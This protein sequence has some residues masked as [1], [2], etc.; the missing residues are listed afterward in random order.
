MRGGNFSNGVSRSKPC[1]YAPS[2]SVRLRIAEPEPA[3]RPPSKSG[4]LQSLMILE[5]SKS[6]FEPRPLHA[7]HARNGD[8]AIGARELFGKSVFLAADDGDGDEATR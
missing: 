2:S 6:N 3:P 1:A 7:G 8:A 5:G 4:R